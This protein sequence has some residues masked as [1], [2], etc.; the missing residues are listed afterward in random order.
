M[1]YYINVYQ[2]TQ[3]ETNLIPFTF[4]RLIEYSYRNQA[5]KGV[6]FMKNA[7]DDNTKF[8]HTIHVKDGVAT[9]I[10]LGEDNE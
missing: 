3:E 6:V 8:L 9:I 7:Y 5:K 1:E 4:K 2:V 10:N